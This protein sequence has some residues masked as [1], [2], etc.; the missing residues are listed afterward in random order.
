MEIKILGTRGEIKEKARGHSKQSGILIDNCLLVDC[1]EKS[2]LQYK[3]RWILFSHLHPDHAYF[4]RRGKEEDLL[5]DIPFFVPEAPLKGLH[6]LRRKKTLGPYEI[7]PIPTHHSKLVKSMAYLIK[8]KEKSLL[9][10][11]DLVWI[12][13]QYHHLFASV[14][15]VITEA[16]FLREGGMIRR[17]KETGEPFG[18]T[19]IPNLI[20]LFKPYTP[21]ILFTHFGSWFYKNPRKARAQ[22]HALGREHQIKVI[23]ARDGLLVNL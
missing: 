12:D 6:L 15:L 7:T 10:T 23:V 3:P 5:P 1:G 4:M 16:S 2:Y 11:S 9:Y 19:G 14:D 17:D 21:Q 20:R 13:K 22:L 18:H 8:K